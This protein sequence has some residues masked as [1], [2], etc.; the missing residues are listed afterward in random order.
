MLG[1]GRGDAVCPV[2][3][4]ARYVRL[5]GM[6]GCPVCPAVRLSGM[7]GCPVYSARLMLGHPHSAAFPYRDAVKRPFKKR[8]ALTR[9]EYMSGGPAARYARRSGCPVCP[10]ARYVR[11]PGMSGCPAARYV[12]L[13]GMSGCPVCPA[14][15]YARLPGMSG[16]PA[17]RRG[18]TG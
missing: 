8:L 6:S 9:A 16:G 14:V 7:S 5:P 17:V 1:C 4:A 10:A 18:V 3:P 12:R 15:R 2:C 13:P 11:L